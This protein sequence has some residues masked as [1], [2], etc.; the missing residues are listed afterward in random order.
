MINMPRSPVAGQMILHRAGCGS[1]KGARSSSSYWTSHSG[2]LCGSREELEALA[3]QAGCCELRECGICLRDPPSRTSSGH[4]QVKHAPESSEADADSR[5]V[6]LRG[7][8]ARLAWRRYIPWFWA[9]LVVVG[10]PLLAGWI[11]WHLS[12][13]QLTFLAIGFAA[14]FMAA[15]IWHF[16][17]IGFAYEN[18]GGE[19]TFTRRLSPFPRQIAT[20]ALAAAGIFFILAG[21]R[22]KIGSALS[23]AAWD[24]YTVWQFGQVAGEL[25]FTMVF[26]GIVIAGLFSRKD[27]KSSGCLLAL[28]AGSLV[29][30]YVMARI[31]GNL[32]QEWNLVVGPFRDM[33][34]VLSG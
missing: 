11:L 22:T 34:H 17:T 24:G 8:E 23:P 25:A 13:T 5:E 19:T 14:L 31:T 9:G 21:S 33:W 27:R 29:A 20:P 7:Q 3:R 28:L 4:V 12:T 26:L 1:I 6:V 10:V 2:K 18:V 32:H 30:V 16:G 15:L